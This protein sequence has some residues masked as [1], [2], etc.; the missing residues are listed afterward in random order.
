SWGSRS[1]LILS[2]LTVAG[3]T[4]FFLAPG[5][6][7]DT[8]LWKSDGTAAGT[9]PLARARSLRFFDFSVFGDRLIFV[10]STPARGQELWVSD[11]T[12]RGTQPLTRLPR[13]DAFQ[14]L[15]GSFGVLPLPRFSLGNRFLFLADDGP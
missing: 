6:Q 15:D 5:K 7:G 13:A 4:L 1:D 2:L 3:R 10:A 12:E 11:G 14:A 9:V 8:Q